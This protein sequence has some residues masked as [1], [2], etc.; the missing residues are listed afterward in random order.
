MPHGRARFASKLINSHTGT[1]KVVS[2]INMAGR[3]I[4]LRKAII[5][6][7]GNGK[8]CANKDCYNSKQMMGEIFKQ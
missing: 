2:F 7:A 1:G 6:R 5:R 4:V 8:T 3:G